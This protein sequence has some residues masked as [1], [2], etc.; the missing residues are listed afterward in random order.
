ML[1]EKIGF[2]GS[3]VVTPV[4]FLP[5]SLHGLKPRSERRYR[6][7]R[8]EGVEICKSLGSRIL[9]S[10]K[11]R[12]DRAVGESGQFR[13]AGDR[14]VDAVEDACFVFGLWSQGLEKAQAGLLLSAKFERAHFL[15]LM[16]AA[17]L[18]RDLEV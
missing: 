13:D 18:H 14:G 8:F 17:A 2:L 9:G 1:Q 3:V 16:L 6:L 12:I 4:N 11:F 7:A 10:T 15:R 5:G